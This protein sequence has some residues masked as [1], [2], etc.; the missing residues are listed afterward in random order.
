LSSESVSSNGG[1]RSRSKQV[2]IQRLVVVGYILAVAMPPV[3]F[4]IGLILILL[5]DG[6]ST[7]GLW[8]VLVSIVAAVIWAV[9]ISAGALTA[10]S[11]GY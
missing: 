11:Q 5:P 3:G 8:M 9:M 2:T 7:P 6:R 10:T 1:S 4:A